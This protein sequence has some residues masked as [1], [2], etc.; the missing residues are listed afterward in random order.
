MDMDYSAAEHIIFSPVVLTIRCCVD[1]QTVFFGWYSLSLGEL[2]VSGACGLTFATHRGALRAPPAALPFATQRALR[3]A[4]HPFSPATT[5]PT[6]PLPHRRPLRATTLPRVRARRGLM[7]SSNLHHSPFVLRIL[8]CAYWFCWRHCVD[9]HLT[10]AF[11]SAGHAGHSFRLVEEPPQPPAD[12][13]QPM[14]PAA[15]AARCKTRAA[16][17]ALPAT[18]LRRAGGI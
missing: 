7:P 16:P 12:R 1:S 2:I 14:P 13:C 10:R 5:H 8:C 6:P 3:L 4:R 17:R 15:P 18:P 11:T 9:A